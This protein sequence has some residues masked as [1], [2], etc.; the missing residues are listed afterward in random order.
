MISG[1]ILKGVSSRRRDAR[2]LAGT[3]LLILAAFIADWRLP[4]GV[5]GGVLFVVPVALTLLFLQPVYTWTVAGISAVLIVLDIFLKPAS[6]VPFY[7]VVIN[8]GYAF[9]AVGIVVGIGYLQWRLARQNERL[10]A[11]S[12]ME[13]RERLS[14][15]LHDDLSQLLGSIGA[16]AS[17]VSEL[18]AQKRTEDAQRE[19]VQLRDG[20]GHAYLD[21]RQYITGLRV[22][23]WGDRRFLE[24]LEDFARYFAEQAQLQLSLELPEGGATLRLAPNVEIQA[25]RIVQEALTNT[26]RHA[27]AKNLRIKASLN[28]TSF[29]ITIQ[30]DGQ[31]FDSAN[32]DSRNHLGLEMMRER[33]E[34]VGGEL[35]VTSTPGQGTEVTVRLPY[36]T[37]KNNAD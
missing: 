24:A 16:R 17:A 29:N 12:V 6:G 26:L 36:E 2:L 15:E 9:L 34:L 37:G 5:A 10:A 22:R 3:L 30:D 19:M 1:K 8:R 7:F 25:I 21:V 33:A 11:L 31:G 18:L 23:P 20:I 4:L 35:T 13:E 27:N 28:D 14:R 32:I